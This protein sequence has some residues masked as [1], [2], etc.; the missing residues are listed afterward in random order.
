MH[1]GINFTRVLRAISIAALL[2]ASGGAAPAQT[3]QDKN[4]CF[5]T[6]TKDY[7]NPAFYD[8]GLAACE[9]FIRSRQYQGRDLAYYVRQKANWLHRKKDFEG[10]LKEFA[11]AIELDPDH[12]ESYD[13]RAD[14][15]LDLGQFE[16]AIDEYNRAIRIDPNYAAAYFS[17]GRAYEK[18]G[19]IN[20]AK[21]SYRRA[22]DAPARDRIAEWAHNGARKRLNELGR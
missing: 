12:V 11:Y 15:F 1:A 7:D 6:G 5:S 16:K 22:L 2:A 14:V 3:E 21:E 20:D 17:R 18:L 9:K 4:N 10:A 8:T 19:R 13:Y